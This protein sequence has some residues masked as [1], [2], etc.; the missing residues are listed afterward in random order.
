MF[1]SFVVF[2][3]LLAVTENLCKPIAVPCLDGH[4][5]GAAKFIQNYENSA[6]D[7]YGENTAAGSAQDSHLCSL[8][9]HQWSG[10]S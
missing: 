10:C 5:R 6:S 4:C 2:K 8:F 9:S 7:M 1:L 3:P